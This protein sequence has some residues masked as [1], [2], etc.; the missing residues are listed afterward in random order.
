MAP[1][2]EVMDNSQ[3]SQGKHP[4]MMVNLILFSQI[5]RKPAAKRPGTGHS[6]KET[7]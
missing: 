1:V 6:L 3:T 2:L 5:I 4:Q 7:L